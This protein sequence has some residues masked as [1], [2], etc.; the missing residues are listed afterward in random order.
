[1]SVAAT[2]EPPRSRRKKAEGMREIAMRWLWEKVVGFLRDL[3]DEDED[4]NDEDRDDGEGN[5]LVLLN[6]EMVSL[7][8][9]LGLG[10][11]EEEEEGG[12]E[13]EM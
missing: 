12:E 1:M 9:G 4:E 6:R 8:L 11:E 5:S 13:I 10:F 3:E 7:G 2:V